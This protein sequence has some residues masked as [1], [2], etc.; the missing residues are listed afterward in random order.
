[1]K[2][3][4]LIVLLFSSSAIFFLL[5]SAIAPSLGVAVV[6]AML[7]GGFLAVALLLSQAF[8]QFP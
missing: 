6:S 2:G 1:M 7:S 3:K 4:V 8:F 5:Y